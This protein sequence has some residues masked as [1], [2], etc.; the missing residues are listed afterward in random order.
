MTLIEELREYE[1]YWIGSARA[2]DV[3]RDTC[4]RAATEIERLTALLDVAEETIEELAGQR[5]MLVGA[6]KWAADLIPASATAPFEDGDD[7]HCPACEA[8]AKVN[9]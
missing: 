8:L 2:D 5:D 1:N 9:T 3:L 6:I 4:G 7:C